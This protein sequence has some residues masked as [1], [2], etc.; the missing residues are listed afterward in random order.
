[1][2]SCAVRSSEKAEWSTCAAP[3]SAPTRGAGADARGGEDGSD[4]RRGATGATGYFV[5][6]SYEESDNHMVTLI[7]R[8]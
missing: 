4:R 7:R 6:L 8:E 1:M 2:A 5:S 3:A